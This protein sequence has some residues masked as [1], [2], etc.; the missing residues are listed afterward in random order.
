MDGR[1]QHLATA[2]GAENNASTVVG[3]HVVAAAVVAS[4]E[5]ANIARLNTGMH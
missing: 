4:V 5:T 1:S 3:Q 2:T